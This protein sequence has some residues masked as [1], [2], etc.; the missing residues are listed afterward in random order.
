MKR[1]MIR[2]VLWL[3]AAAILAGAGLVTAV[4]VCA[5]KERVARPSDCI[6]VLGARVW[7]SGR[8][9]NALRYRCETALQAWKDGTAQNIIVTGGQGTDEPAT[10]ASVMRA[11][12]IEKGVPEAQVI[13]EDTSTSTIQNLANAK[14][15]MNQNGWETAAVV[16]NDYHVERALWIA[17]DVGVDACG[18]AAPSPE[19]LSTR[20]ISRLRESLSWVL[21][22]LRRL[23]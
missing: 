5:G 19:R 6:V 3:M 9:S 2:I 18:I 1:M 7:P 20:V 13:A 17:R 8:M 14:E 4:C 12:F 23:L 22:A 10:E 15:I 11:Y 16:T 21:Y